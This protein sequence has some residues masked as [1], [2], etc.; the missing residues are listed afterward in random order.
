MR[1]AVYARESAAH[2][3]TAARAFA[4]GLKRFGITAGVHSTGT[5]TPSDLAVF[6]GHRQHQIMQRQR[7][8]GLDYLVMERGYIGDRFQYTSLGFNGLNGRAEFYA[9]N[10]PASRGDRFRGTIKPWHSGEY[11]LICGQVIG[12]A[13]LN[14]VDYPAWVMSLPREINGLPVMFRPHPVRFGYAVPFP[15]TT[16][17]LDE[18]LAG[19]A[20]V[21]T[22][23][24]NSAVDALLAGTPAI[25]CDAGSMV[26]GDVGHSTDDWRKPHREEIINRLAWCQWTLDEIAAGAAWDHLRQRYD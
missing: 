18:D 11:Y 9:D 3:I 1:V 25:A 26:Y 20:G 16:G 15:L 21:I 6:W 2:Q 23:N 4:E 22:F 14:E 19:A 17:S 12:D 24:S 7:S 10:M 5:Y 13:S 8:K